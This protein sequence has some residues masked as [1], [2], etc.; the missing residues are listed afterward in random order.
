MGPLK[1]ANGS[2]ES[3]CAPPAESK[4][5]PRTKTNLVNYIQCIAVKKPLVAIILNILSTM[6]FVFEEINWRW[7]RH[8]TIPLSHIRSNV[9]DGVSPP[10]RGGG[11]AG[12]APSKPAAT[13]L[14]RLCRDSVLGPSNASGQHEALRYLFQTKFNLDTGRRC[15]AVCRT[16][17]ST[18][19][20]VFQKRPAT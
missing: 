1:L 16:R 14:C 2:G 3:L 12:S 18:R 5:E 8:N 15:V 19:F 11:G 10:P 4:A 6:F 7:C 20:G 9:S 13:N 17:H